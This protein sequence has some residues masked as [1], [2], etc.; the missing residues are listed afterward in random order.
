MSEEIPEFMHKLVA[1]TG[2][3]NCYLCKNRIMGAHL[4]YMDKDR[5]PQKVCVG[6]C[7]KAIDVYIAKLHG[8]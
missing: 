6:C 2:V 7:Y 8:E 5:N 1:A 4:D 3:P